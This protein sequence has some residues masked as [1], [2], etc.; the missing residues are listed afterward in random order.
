M[1]CIAQIVGRKDTGKTAVLERVI[2]QLKKEGFSVLVIKHSHHRLDLE[3]K[4]TYR[5]RKSGADYVAFRDLDG[6]AVFTDDPELLDSLKVDVIL[7]EGFSN[8]NSPLRYE[9]RSPEEIEPLA[10]KVLED[11]NQCLRGAKESY[12]FRPSDILRVAQP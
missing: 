5:L 8:F 11:L 7:V 9:I 6:I 1:V 3:G 4:D 12:N 2:S 10:R